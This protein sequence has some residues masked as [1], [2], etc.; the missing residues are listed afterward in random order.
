MI[1]VP[2]S[3]VDS[4]RQLLTH[5]DMS[6]YEIEVRDNKSAV[7]CF[8]A[9]RCILG[10]HSDVFRAMFSHEDI[11]ETV[12]RR[13]VIEEFSSTAVYAML[14]YMYTG[15]LLFMDLSTDNF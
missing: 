8:S 13:I 12:E 5:G 1:S 14:E 9:H 11:R 10:A 6:D 3:F 4:Q 2:R 7:R 15:M